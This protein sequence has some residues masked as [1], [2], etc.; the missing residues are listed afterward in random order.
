[1]EAE[2]FRSMAASSLRSMADLKREPW[3]SARLSLRLEPRTDEK[4]NNIPKLSDEEKAEVY[5]REK[6]VASGHPVLQ[7][8]NP[9]IAEVTQKFPDGG[10]K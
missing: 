9:H 1:M 5:G 2:T 8:M 6:F 3:N 10:R 7:T 4:G